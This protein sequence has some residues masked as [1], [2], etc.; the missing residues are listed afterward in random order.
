M[1]FS[2]PLLW[3]GWRLFNRSIDVPANQDVLGWDKRWPGGCGTRSLPPDAS[4]YV[5]LQR[6]VCVVEGCGL[7]ADG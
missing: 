1:F 5:C 2:R 3:D 6:N 4:D 7:L